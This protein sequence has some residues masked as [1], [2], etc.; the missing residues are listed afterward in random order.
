MT[1]GRTT[2]T[3]TLDEQLAFWRH[4]EWSDTCWLWTGQK[5]GAR[6]RAYGLFTI[7]RYGQRIRLMAHRVA[8]ETTDELLPTGFFACHKCDVAA[9]VRPDH[10]YAGTPLSNARDALDRGRHPLRDLDYARPPLDPLRPQRG[11]Y[12]RPDWALLLT[13]RRHGDDWVLLDDEDYALLRRFDAI[14][15]RDDVARF[16][17]RVDRGD[18]LALGLSTAPEITDGRLIEL[19]AEKAVA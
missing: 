12:R 5:N 3:L 9:C 19:Y 14:Q 1:T 7:R 8:L 13:R 10:L 11:R 6:E 17:A 2:P 16:V 18:G 15:A 4:V